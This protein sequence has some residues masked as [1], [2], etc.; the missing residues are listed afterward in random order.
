[1][2][3]FFSILILISYQCFINQIIIDA[4]PAAVNKFSWAFP[5]HDKHEDISIQQL[6]KRKG[7]GMYIT[8]KF[9]FSNKIHW[10]YFRLG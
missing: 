10:L 6:V 3:F 7:A 1:M 9:S 4:R 5:M 8:K 2:K